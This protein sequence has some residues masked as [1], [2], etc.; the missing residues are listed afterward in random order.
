MS[1]VYGTVT[2]TNPSFYLLR[3]WEKSFSIIKK[4]KTPVV[5]LNNRVKEL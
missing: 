3:I 1:L 4:D 5:G 2:V